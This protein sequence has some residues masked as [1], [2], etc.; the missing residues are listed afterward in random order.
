MQGLVSSKTWLDGKGL[1][2]KAAACYSFRRG[3]A[4]CPWLVLVANSSMFPSQKMGWLGDAKY[5]SL[6]SRSYPLRNVLSSWQA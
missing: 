3:L 5:A 4:V 1:M 6:T 2:E